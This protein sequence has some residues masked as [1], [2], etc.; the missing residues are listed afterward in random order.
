MVTSTRTYFGFLAGLGLERLLELVR[1]RRNAQRML[2]RGGIEVGRSH[3]PA[4]VAVHG[5]FFPACALEVLLLRRPFRVASG[6]VALGAT[7][8]AQALRYWAIGTLKDRWC[9]R[10]VFVPGEAPVVSGPYRYLRHPNYVAVA[11]ELFAVP[12]IHGAWLS[13]LVFSL[14]NAVLMAIRIPREE[15]ALGRRYR[16]VFAS[17]PRFL[18]EL[19]HV[20]SH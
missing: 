14:S 8:L 6:L 19:R 17:K 3:Y 18:P 20:T 10:I 13:A 9:T 7:A 16:E 12:L 4:M 1:S 2:Q 11:M 5:L 15:K